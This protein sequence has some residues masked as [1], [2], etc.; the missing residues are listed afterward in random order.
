MAPSRREKSWSHHLEPSPSVPDNGSVGRDLWP[1]G[2]TEPDECCLGGF[3]FHSPHASPFPCGR[4][5]IPLYYAPAS[6]CVRI[7]VASH[8]E[9]L[10]EASGAGY[11][12]FNCR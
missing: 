5:L 10:C 9:I 12:L 8:L 7:V 1:R 6:P 11:F 2:G 4:L 3:A